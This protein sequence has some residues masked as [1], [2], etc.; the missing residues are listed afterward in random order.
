MQGYTCLICLQTLHGSLHNRCQ[1][2]M[3]MCMSRCET[4]C[5][6][7]RRCVDY[8]QPG[9]TLRELHNLSIQL[10]SEGLAELGVCGNMS[11]GA[12][13]RDAYSTFYPHSVGE[14]LTVYKKL[15]MLIY[16]CQMASKL[17]VQIVYGSGKFVLQ[18][19]PHGMQDTIWEAMCMTQRQ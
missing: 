1:I 7:H 4:S 6:V 16:L 10:L 18:L 11:P 9:H 14:R 19:I 2:H 5:C 13:A 17:R 8:C 15:L 12:I 3:Q